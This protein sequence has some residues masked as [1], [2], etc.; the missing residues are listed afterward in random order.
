M[1][2]L[3]RRRVAALCALVCLTAACFFFPSPYGDRVDGRAVRCVGRVVAADDSQIHQLGLIRKGSQLLSLMIEDGPFEGRRVQAV[4]Q[5]LGRM[6]IDKVFRPGDRAL[7]VLSLNAKG[8]IVFVAAQDHWRI[9]W[10]VGL[11]GLFCLLPLA[12][13]GWTGAKA[14]G[15]F[16]FSAVLIW[17]VMIPA[18]LKGWDPVPVALAAT[19]L[20]TAVI[21][22][23]VA[24]FSRRGWT[25]FLGAMLGVVTSCVLAVVFVPLFHANGAV[26]PFSETMLYA[27][28]AHLSLARLFTAAIFV[29]AS[30]AL[31][32]LAMDVA[33]A[34][35]EVA[36]ARPDYSF[37]RLLSSGL[38]VGRAVVGT[39]TTTLLL[40][41]S[42][43]YMTLLMAFMAQ[44]VPVV[45]L[46][47]HVYVASEIL[48]TL[49]GSFGLVTVA[50]FTA[51][52]GAFVYGRTWGATA[53]RRNLKAL[54]AAFIGKRSALDVER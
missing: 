36:R 26:L 5:L 15:S 27:G 35:E 12:F 17:R 19:S 39:M 46:M 54:G 14:L 29:A 20:L 33:S 49:V 52:V 40:A 43:G 30:G 22:F 45:N 25:A 53:F 23:M 51:V 31:M 21:I 9:G 32:D 42:G 2:G 47:N 50:P 28:Y 13:A 7:V 11:L 34:M 38:H 18:F 41:Y 24:G 4:N 1:E 6:D 44:G 16:L 48:K 37:S 3:W 8:G 10:E